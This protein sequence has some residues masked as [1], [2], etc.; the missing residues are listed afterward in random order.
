MNVFA[1]T[2]SGRN[3]MRKILAGLAAAL[4][5][6]LAIPALGADLAD[7]MPL[8]QSV[9]APPPPHGSTVE[10]NEIAEI[11]KARA[12]A[13]PQALALA[14]HDN[15]TEDATIFT[16]AIGPGWDVYKLPQ[17]LALLKLVGHVDRHAS[18][19]AKDY[20]HRDRPW[21]V[22]ARVQTCAPHAAGPAANSYPSGHTLLGYEMGVVLA[23]LMPNHAA[24]IMA[25][26]KQYGENRIL[27]GF[28]F[29]SDVAAGTQ[30]G[31]AVARAMLQDPAFHA[32]FLQA[33]A[34]LKGAGLAR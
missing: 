3:A 1:G 26:A 27:C 2:Q 29:R 10:R 16:D 14:R 15:D 12:N 21:I 32:Q 17:T 31:T 30:Y 4:L 6:T 19:K 34:E 8:P 24:A 18:A 28:H 9:L 33:Q 23:S 7:E 5:L 11:L 22:D 20:F 25:R 13:T